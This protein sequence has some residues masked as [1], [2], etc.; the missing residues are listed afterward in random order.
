M[1]KAETVKIFRNDQFDGWS[2]WKVN[3]FSDEL[4]FKKNPINSTGKVFI[5][6]MDSSINLTLKMIDIQNS[7]NTS[8]E[9]NEKIRNTETN[10]R[11]SVLTKIAKLRSLINCAGVK[12]IQLFNLSADLKNEEQYFLNFVEHSFRKNEEV[13]KVV[14]SLK[15]QKS[16]IKSQRSSQSNFIENQISKISENNKILKENNTNLNEKLEIFQHKQQRNEFLMISKNQKIEFLQKTVNLNNSL[17]DNQTKNDL[18]TKKIDSEISKL[19]EDLQNRNNDLRNSKNEQ[20]ALNE[21]IFVLKSKFTLNYKTNEKITKK[22]NKLL[23]DIKDGGLCLESHQLKCSENRVMLQN[24]SK[25]L[26]FKIQ[27]LELSLLKY[28]HLALF[29]KKLI[30]KLER[31]AGSEDLICQKIGE[32]VYFQDLMQVKIIK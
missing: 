13:T 31:F 18:E 8:E 30:Q 16:M 29:S 22:K 2:G 23:H 11:N 9:E 17:I 32:S 20:K 19:L 25:I 24:K 26:G 1:E 15:S 7:I 27:E 3:H 4:P 5:E 10:L 12:T 14:L 28:K 6:I 21:E